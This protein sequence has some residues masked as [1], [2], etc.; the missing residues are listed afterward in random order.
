[1]VKRFYNGLLALY[2]STPM[3]MLAFA[4]FVIA[5][6]DTKNPEKNLRPLW[7]G[8]AVIL[9]VLM[10][11]YY[12][13]KLGI[14]KSLRNVKNQDAYGEGG[15]LDRSFI[16]EDRMIAGYGFHCEEHSTTGITK[17][18]AQEKGKHVQLFVTS[19]EGTFRMDAVDVNEARRF[20]AFIKRKNPD[21]VLENI[22]TRGKGTLQELG[23]GKY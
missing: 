2:F 20:A 22:V 8:T 7:I 12:R 15:M 18:E 5:F 16:L 6:M 23:A 17:L 13:F 3:T 19:E 11:F 14:A 10:F 4:V 21:C 1:M 9:A